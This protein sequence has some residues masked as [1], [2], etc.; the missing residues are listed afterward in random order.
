[1]PG[2]CNKPKGMLQIL[3]ERGLIDCTLVNTPRSMR[4]SKKGKA[5]DFSEDTGE[6]LHEF[7]NIR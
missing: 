4:Y 1:M 2:W 5:K 3:F 6:L 7:K